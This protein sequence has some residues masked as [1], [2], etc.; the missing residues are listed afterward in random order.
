MKEHYIS[1]FDSDAE[2][3]EVIDTSER[4]RGSYLVDWYQPDEWTETYELVD[5]PTGPFI[6]TLDGSYSFAELLALIHFHPKLVERCSAGET[7]PKSDEVRVLELAVQN[8]SEAL[9]ELL[10]DCTGPV[11]DAFK[12]LFN[13]VITPPSRKTYM[14][15]RSC[16]PSGYSMSLTKEKP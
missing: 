15:A 5:P 13:E 9:N 10:T 11:P 2:A 4:M 7:V 6:I 14:K 1:P 3:R 12:H 8:L 16:L